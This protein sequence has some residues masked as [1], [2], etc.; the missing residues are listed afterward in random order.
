MFKVIFRILVI[1]LIVA[2]ISG[3]IYAFVQNTSISSTF[4]RGGI[5]EGAF[6][7]RPLASSSSATFSTQTFSPVRLGERGDGRFSFSLGRGVSGVLGN[8]VLIISI[9]MVVMLL[10]KAMAP[11]ILRV[12]P[13]SVDQ[14]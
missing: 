5:G 12:R 11:R 13:V 8:S 3:G 14:P 6:T 4:G 1:L 7:G 2:I 9:T 10:R